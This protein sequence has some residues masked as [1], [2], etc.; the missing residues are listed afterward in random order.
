ML[1]ILNTRWLDLLVYR[2]DRLWWES[3]ACLH[4]WLCKPGRKFLIKRRN[5]TVSQLIWK[6]IGF[7]V[8]RVPVSFSDLVSLKAKVCSNRL[9]VGAHS[10]SFF[11]VVPT[12]VLYRVFEPFAEVA[13]VHALYRRAIQILVLSTPV[14]EDGPPSFHQIVLDLITILADH[15]ACKC[16]LL[17]NV[18]VHVLLQSLE[19]RVIR[20]RIH[21][22]FNL[23]YFKYKR[24][25]IK[26]FI[27]L[28]QIYSN[29][30]N[31]S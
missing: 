14:A 24:Y 10:V 4:L 27:I 22:L 12:L 7:K 26:F 5:F 28:A 11:I 9:A 6:L 30:R 23:N 25:S 16:L 21:M 8:F 31:E 19:L 29:F 20:L 15:G 3:V 1:S 2:R 13:N 18:L 17:Q